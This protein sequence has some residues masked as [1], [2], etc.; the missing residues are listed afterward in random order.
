MGQ[1]GYIRALATVDPAAL[2]EADEITGLYAFQLAALR[3]GDLDSS[4]QL[5][6][7]CPYLLDV[8]EQGP[9]SSRKEKK[10][11]D[12]RGMLSWSSWSC[13]RNYT[14]NREGT[15]SSGGGLLQSGTL[16]GGLDF[17]SLRG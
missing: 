9:L 3:R 6:C 13:P 7:M 17:L 5:L 4:H 12:E 15:T 2:E 10:G 16:C 8:T 14:S 11:A 1:E